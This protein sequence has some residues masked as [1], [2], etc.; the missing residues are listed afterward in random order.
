M[1]LGEE[2][3]RGQSGQRAPRTPARECEGRPRSPAVQAP[4][5]PSVPRPRGRGRGVAAKLS[6]ENLEALRE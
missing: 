2:A 3:L 6:E 4:E 5:V 1:S